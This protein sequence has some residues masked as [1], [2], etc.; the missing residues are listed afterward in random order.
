MHVLSRG[1]R[2][3]RLLSGWV[4][5]DFGTEGMY[6]SPTR[7]VERQPLCPADRRNREKWAVCHDVLQRG[8][9]G[10][11]L[12]AGGTH[13]ICHTHPGHGTVR[14]SAVVLHPGNS[15]FFTGQRSSGGLSRHGLRG[16]CRLLFWLSAT[17]GAYNGIYRRRGLHLLGKPRRNLIFSLRHRVSAAQAPINGLRTLM[18]MSVRKA[19]IPKTL[20]SC[21][22]SAST[23]LIFLFLRATILLTRSDMP[24]VKRT[25]K[26]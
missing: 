17:R 3:C 14:F 9:S 12:C 22:F 11:S 21:P 10:I 8:T 24:T 2:G 1:G 26:R 25:V 7:G 16:A 15:G 4:L 18:S 20:Y 13:I 23:I 6:L 5:R 19:G